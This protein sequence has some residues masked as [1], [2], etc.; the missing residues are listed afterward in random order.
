MNERKRPA[1]PHALKK[2]ESGNPA[3]RTKGSRNKATMLVMK[4]MEDDAAAITKT[5]I[6]A[7]KAG[8]LAAA[9]LVIDRLAPPAK[10]RPVFVALPATDT[11]EGIAQAQDA[12]LQAVAAGDL[13][14]GEAATLAG[15]V[16]GRRKALETEEL[17]RRIAALEVQHEGD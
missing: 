5:V 14:P 2:G 4:L 7:A 9:K 12:I 10:E 6:D 8:D 3:G 13:L 17:E 15:I 16:E 11:A 1:P